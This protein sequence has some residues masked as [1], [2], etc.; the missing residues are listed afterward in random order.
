MG[1]TAQKVSKSIEFLVFVFAKKA[2]QGKKAKAKVVGNKLNKNF[3]GN[4]VCIYFDVIIQIAGFNYSS[5][6]GNC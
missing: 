1:C 3:Y 2:K 6:L 5:D 4:S